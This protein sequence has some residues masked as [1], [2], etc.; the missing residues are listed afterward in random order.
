M[1]MDDFKLQHA[2]TLGDVFSPDIFSNP[3]ALWAVQCP[4]TVTKSSTNSLE[5]EN[6]Q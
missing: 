5:L 1:N 4:Q 6:W 2:F 3:V